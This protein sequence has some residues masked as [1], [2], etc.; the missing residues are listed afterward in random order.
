M[1]AIQNLWRMTCGPALNLAPLAGDTTADVAVIGGGFTGLSAALH[2]AEAGA[3]VVVLEAET[4]GHG[5]SGRNVGLVN[6]GLWTPPDE[7][8]AALGSEE[9]AALNRALA[10]GPDL[11]FD[12]IARHGIECEA[13]R[14][15]T[16]HLAHNASG[17]RDLQSRHAQQAR[18]GAPVRLLDA[19]E[20]ARRVGTDRF[21]GALWDGRA[22]TIQPLAYAMGLARAAIAAGAVLHEASP[23]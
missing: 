9:G 8:E 1:T 4:V 3:R 13:V 18:R 7:V 23:V 20:T 5:G 12:L 10:A 16:L 14:N 11:V 17:L 15:G 6:A 21:P 2:L 19:A 22:G